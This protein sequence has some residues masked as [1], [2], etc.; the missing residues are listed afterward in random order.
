MLR[1]CRNIFQANQAMDLAVIPEKAVEGLS[2]ARPTTLPNF[3]HRKNFYRHILLHTSTT[4]KRK[5]T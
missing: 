5:I 1:R 4:N 3:N 2:T